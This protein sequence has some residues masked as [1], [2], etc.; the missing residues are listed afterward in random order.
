M[1]DK[2][3]E[4]INHLLNKRSKNIL[5]NKID[6]AYREIENIDMQ[7]SVMKAILNCFKE[8][9]LKKILKA[10]KKARKIEKQLEVE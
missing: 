5:I 3:M 10:T 4:N 8:D 1:K 9:T 6:V 7:Y 2:N